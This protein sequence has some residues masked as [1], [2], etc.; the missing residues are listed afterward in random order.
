MC[1]RFLVGTGCISFILAIGAASA[2]WH[3][4][5]GAFVGLF[6]AIGCGL[7]I[8]MYGEGRPGKK[9]RTVEEEEKFNQYFRKVVAWVG[10]TIGLICA[11]AGIAGG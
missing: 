9:P 4:I 5:M 3:V 8:R 10:I 11:A 2:A 6:A 1:Q 7:M